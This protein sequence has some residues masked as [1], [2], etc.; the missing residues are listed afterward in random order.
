MDTNNEGQSLT[1]E[2]RQF[3]QTASQKGYFSVHREITLRELAAEHDMSSQEA[4]EV[5]RT[6]INTAMREEV[7][8]NE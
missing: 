3:L 1:V 6:A 4:S 2:H 8:V 7:F 5:L